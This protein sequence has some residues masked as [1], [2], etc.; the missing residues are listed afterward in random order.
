MKETTK[1]G[2]WYQKYINKWI[3]MYGILSLISCFLL[4]SLIYTGTQ[5]ALKNAYH[6]DLTSA[7]DRKVP[8]VQ[9]WVWVYVICFAFWA[10]SY[11]LITREGKE[12]WFRFAAADMMS[13]LICMVFFIVLPTTNVRPE[14]TGDGLTSWLMRF[15]YQ[16]DAPTNLF[17]SIHCLVSWFCFI[18][19]RKSKKVPVWYKV[20]ACVFALLVC[21]STQFTKQHY[22]IDIPGGILL[23]EL[24]W[25]L[26]NHTEIYRAWQRFFDGIGKRIF[27][28][29]YY[30]E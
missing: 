7:L 21:A 17:P 14:V 2:I 26:T 23:A 20:F 24:C 12:K 18:G 22:L 10:V 5:L 13:R 8:F 19:I 27:G 11:I 9:E 28:V 1:P 6:Y 25:Y 4:N 30:D 3:P 15:I 29:R 16:M